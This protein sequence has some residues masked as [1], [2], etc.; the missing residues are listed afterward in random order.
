MATRG[1]IRLPTQCHAAR[2]C[3]LVQEVL[4]P[5]SRV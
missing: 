5:A 3:A 4:R 2:A 1:S